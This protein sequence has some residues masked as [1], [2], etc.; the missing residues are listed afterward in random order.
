MLNQKKHVEIIINNLKNQIK[1]LGIK[2]DDDGEKKI[3]IVLRKKAVISQRFDDD[4]ISFNKLYN[5]YL[6]TSIRQFVLYRFF[7]TVFIFT[8]GL[9]FFLVYLST[10]F[11]I[12]S[13]FKIAIKWLIGY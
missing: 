2:I 10:R 5:S 1:S 11:H 6:V 8:L 3:K 9:L 12:L 4:K 7:S 13:F